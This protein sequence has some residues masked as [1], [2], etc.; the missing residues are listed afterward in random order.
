MS[1]FKNVKKTGFN[2]LNTAV[3]LYTV[4]TG[5]TTNIIS[6]RVINRD[7]SDAK[8]FIGVFPGTYTDLTTPLIPTVSPTGAPASTVAY[9]YVTTIHNYA[10]E[11]LQSPTSVVANNSATLSD[12]VYNTVSFAT[13]GTNLARIYRSI[14]Q[15]AGPFYFIKAVTGVTSYQDKD[16]SIGSQNELIQPPFVNTT[17]V[18]TRLLSEN[19]VISGF[20]YLVDDTKTLGLEAG[21]KIICFSNSNYVDIVISIDEL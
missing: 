10:G 20:S 9:Y 14:A 19:T 12:T 4:P 2:T 6:T 5:K 15:S 17:M 21:K 7:S 13:P 11:T 16:S 3:V 18:E 1:A 8:V